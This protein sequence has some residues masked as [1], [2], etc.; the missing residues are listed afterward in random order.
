M[1]I[2]L[3]TIIRIESKHEPYV[4]LR[5]NRSVHDASVAGDGDMYHQADVR[6][7]SHPATVTDSINE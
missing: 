3:T 2:L 1:M 7:G 6:P 4:P 5:E